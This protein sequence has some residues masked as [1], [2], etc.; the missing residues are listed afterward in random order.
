[1]NQNR[2]S[3][4]K[5]WDLHIHTPYSIQQHYGD[6]T[7]PTVWE[8]FIK[9]IEQLPED[10]KAIGI[11]DY[12]SLEGYKKVLEFKSKGRLKNID[13]ILPVIELRT[14]NIAGD[15]CGKT[16][17]VN[18][19]V[20]F[21]DKLS[22]EEIENDF[23]TQLNCKVNFCEDEHSLSLNE[24]NIKKVGRLFKESQPE[25]VKQNITDEEAGF[26]TFE[27]LIDDI[28]TQLQKKIFRSKYVTAIGFAEWNAIKWS[29]TAG[30]KRTIIN[31]CDFCLTACSNE[32]L[33]E[34]HRS[35]LV[36]AG[37]NSKLI[38]SSDAHFLHSH[39]VSGEERK[40]GNSYTWIKSETSFEGLQ[41]LKFEYEDRYRFS[42]LKLTEKSSQLVIDSIEFNTSNDVFG[43]QVIHLSENLNAIIG[44]KSS[45]KSLLLYAMA[46][47]I[48]SD[49]VD[50][51]NKTQ[52]QNGYSFTAD[53]KF[54]VKWKDG[55]ECTY[56]SN[57]LKKITYIPQLYINYIAENNKSDS[58]LNKIVLDVLKSRPEFLNEYEKL[59]N[60][61]SVY[62]NEL[63]Q[64]INQYHSK[65]KMFGEKQEQIKNIGDP[66]GFKR[67]IAILDEKIAQLQLISQF[68]KEETDQYAS[69]T[70]DLE[71][72]K[73]RYNLLEI[74]SNQIQK[75][76]DVTS[77]ASDSIAKRLINSVSKNFLFEYNNSQDTSDRLKNLL[78]EFLSKLESSV[79]EQFKSLEKGLENARSLSS[80]E[81][82]RNEALQVELTAKIA[83]YASKLTS[84][85]QY[86]EM[87]ESKNEYLKKISSVIKLREE[88]KQI[89]L[90]EELNA[91]SELHKKVFETNKG[92]IE[93]TRQ[94]SRFPE[95]DN[96]KL[97]CEYGINHD[98]IQSE[99]CSK[100]NRK[101][102][103]KD[104]LN[105]VQFDDENKFIF[106][107]NTF[108]DDIQI[109][110]QAII[111]RNESLTLNGGNDASSLIHGIYANFI[112]LKFDIEKAGDKLL[113][114][115][116]GKKGLTLFQLFLQLNNSSSPILIDQPEDNLDNRTVY[117]EL[118]S[119]IRKKKI[120]RQ[121]IM[122]THNPNLVV[123]TDAE[124]VIV[125][126]Q[127][128]Q[129]SG[130][131]RHNQFEYVNGSLENSYENESEQGILYK[132]GIRQ[133]VCE[134]LEG[135]EDAFKKRESKYQF[136]AKK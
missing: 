72:V 36:N 60:K 124:N 4:W 109:I 31:N 67:D 98:K 6:K 115:S 96:L 82:K 21:S 58:G 100:F 87:I 50:S 105:V 135:G 24:E 48:D 102:R 52:N 110:F 79:S 65:L 42:L 81:I 112:Y 136:N 70:A 47:S 10:F 106:N 59:I 118:N 3:T 89:N 46:K 111:K 18:Y 44:G 16:N 56:P 85:K 103:V 27:V 54:N 61:L 80:D 113:K 26:N 77:N 74:E 53:F 119:F 33:F 14:R 35:S 63:H 90:Q 51:I 71:N 39:T 107:E 45:G 122:V 116:P 92:L 5:R 64:T 91:I 94:S 134:I 1:M 68:T 126:N 11:N 127:Q 121:I 30:L 19:H 12:Y 73:K 108:L 99:F 17:R 28:E 2:G 66:D 25:S 104:Q 32:D 78:S 86:S 125:A 95:G 55:D 130:E 57:S 29:Q 37:I 40:I 131:N 101:R 97:I 69:I 7:N 120:E 83:A 22:A 128:G 129:G 123:S 62:Q 34:K 132:K 76:C 117:A 9:S 75:I 41:Q 20:I 43:K 15:I 8:E 49:Q 23:L 88:Q 133:H 13:L 114:M 38:H 93:L 84:Q